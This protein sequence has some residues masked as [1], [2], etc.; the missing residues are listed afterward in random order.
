M[1]FYRD[2]VL[3]SLQSFW[4]TEPCSLGDSE[5]TPVSHLLFTYNDMAC[6]CYLCY[7]ATSSV[8]YRQ[9]FACYRIII[10]TLVSFL[11]C[12]IINIGNMRRNNASLVLPKSWLVLSVAC[13]RL[14][15]K[16]VLDKSG[17]W[18]VASGVSWLIDSVDALSFYVGKCASVQQ[19]QKHVL[20][21]K[22]IIYYSMCEL[23]LQYTVSLHVHIFILVPLLHVSI[24]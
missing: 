17:S 5:N 13:E 9:Y 10:P 6:L 15:Q 1:D 18:L 8:V 12:R 4:E 20:V 3:L 2:N 24:S 11:D 7:I 23:Y 19:C 22:I 21:C 14:Q 16:L